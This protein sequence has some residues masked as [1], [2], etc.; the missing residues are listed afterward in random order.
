MR[1]L[2][3]SAVFTILA[4]PLFA[5]D[6]ALLMG[7]D[8]YQEF[9]RV[10]GGT[11]VVVGISALRDAGYRVSSLENGAGQD[12]RRLLDRLAV[13][14]AGA[15][16]LVVGLS[17]RFVTDG[18]RTWLLAADAPARPGLFMLEDAVSLDS[19]LAVLAQAPG[20][21]VLVL[22][23]DASDTSQIDPYLRQGLGDLDI[24]QGVTVFSGPPNVA[25]NIMTDAIAVQ[26]GDVMEFARNTRAVQIAGYQPRNLVMQTDRSVVVEPTQANDPSLSFWQDAQAANTADAYRVFLLG[27]PG[28]PYA[29]EAGRRLDQIENDPVRLAEQAEAMLGLTT[30]QRRAIQGNLTLLDYDTRGVDGI[31]GQGTRRAIRNWQQ[32]NG[33]EQTSYLT[34]EQINRIDAQASRR[35]AEIDVAN[36]AI[37]AEAERLDR[38]YWEETGARG[39]QAGYRAY[40]NRYPEG[41]F[42]DEAT[43]ALTP[44]V[45]V[46]DDRAR[47]QEQALNINPVMGRLIESRLS[48][49][50]FDPGPV[51]GQFDADTRRAIGQYQADRSMNATGYLDQPTLA[52]LLADAFG[53]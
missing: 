20:Q 23:L 50:G 21:A 17:G 40:L 11:D 13:D 37:Q 42:A 30:A 52:R 31:F 16:R 14:A 34:A 18:R 10:A 8:R 6:L 33:F 27:H 9:R 15:E 44:A 24:P 51:D 3:F 46:E 43:R 47:A 45:P 1:R 32:I 35:Q 38:A 39:T 26:G 25:D 28:S 29:A 36:A 2:T 53:R 41:V 5:D 22:G 48:Q 4:S 49:M 19:V 12:M 7:V